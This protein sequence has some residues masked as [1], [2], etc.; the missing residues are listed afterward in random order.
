[1][2]LL[3]QLIVAR[4]YRRPERVRG[5]WTSPAWRVDNSRSLW[6]VVQSSP[7]ANEML[8]MDLEPGWIVVTPPRFGVFWEHVE[9]ENEEGRPELEE[10]FLLHAAGILYYIPWTLGGDMP[11]MK[12]DR[13]LVRPDRVEEKTES[14]II[15]PG[16]IEKRPV[17]GVI[18]DIGDGVEDSELVEGVRILYP[19]YAGTDLQ[20]NGEKRIILEAGQA[21]AIIGD[22][23]RVEVA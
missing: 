6:E 18:T 21:M 16:L 10:R 19:L 7:E 12:G 1:M 14:I 3:H 5:I 9:V 4:K 20:V 15:N 11:K 8:Q 13:I 2:R 23:E 17:T 22:D